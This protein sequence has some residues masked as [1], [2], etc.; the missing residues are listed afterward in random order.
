MTQSDFPNDWALIFN[1]MITFFTVS[2]RILDT[3]SS[4]SDGYDFP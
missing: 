4:V 3:S 2:R 1:R